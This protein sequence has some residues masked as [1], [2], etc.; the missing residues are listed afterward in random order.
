MAERNFEK[1][2]VLID[3]DNTQISKLDDMFTELSLHGRIVVKRAYGNWRKEN[4]KKWEDETK[5]LAI[6]AVQQFD[7]VSGKNA[8]DMALVIDAMDLLYSSLYD[9]FAI[10]SSDSDY[11]PLAIKLH[12][13]GIYV[14]GVGSKKT[15]EPFRNACDEFILLENLNSSEEDED[16][17]EEDS[18]PA[19]GGAGRLSLEGKGQGMENSQKGKKGGKAGMK[20]VHALL[21]AAAESF[22]DS[23][24]YTN[25]SAAGTYIKRVKPDFDVRTYGYKKLTD[26]IE[27][28][29]ANYQVNRDGNIVVYQVR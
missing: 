16:S 29:P 22:Q 10:I 24:G 7:Y 13:S 17:D 14:F 2:A 27:A 26:L 19:Q 9:A 21:R 23:R 15:P 20:K 25:V 18:S 4:L 12:E 1:M 5:R 3:A 28:Y 11:T 6:K 8:T